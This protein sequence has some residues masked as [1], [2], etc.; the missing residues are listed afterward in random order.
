MNNFTIH[1]LIYFDIILKQTHIVYKFNKIEI[2]E[3]INKM[4]KNQQLSKITINDKNK[5]W[6]FL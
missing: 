3:N 6:S 4:N 5:I 2:S 1:K